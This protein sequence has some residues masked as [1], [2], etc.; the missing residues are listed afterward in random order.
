MDTGQIQLSIN[1]CI[2]SHFQVTEDLLRTNAELK[3][4]LEERERTFASLELQVH[5]RKRPPLNK[6]CSKQVRHITKILKKDHHVMFDFNE[7]ASHPHNAAII[8]R[9]VEGAM[10]STTSYMFSRQE[11]EEATKRYFTNLKDEHKREMSGT[12]ARHLR[13]M[14]RCSRM[15]NKLKMRLSGL[16]SPYCPLSSEQRQKAEQILHI[17]EVTG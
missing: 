9:I 17:G 13:L 6:E 15:D 7:G 16:K 3:E 10:D 12:K 11:A 4:L 2:D 1:V 8:G 5:K 14:R